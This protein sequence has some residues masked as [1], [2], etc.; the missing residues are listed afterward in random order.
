ME[1]IK[2]KHVFINPKKYYAIEEPDEGTLYFLTNGELYRGSILYGTQVAII[3]N[4][5]IPERGQVNRIYYNSDDQSLSVWKNKKWVHITPTISK[6][7]DL[8]DPNDKDVND[9]LVTVDNLKKYID[10]LIS[11]GK[12]LSASSG[13]VSNLPIGNIKVPKDI[14]VVNQE[15]GN[16]KSGD[17]VRAGTSIEKVLENLLTKVTP[18][19]YKKPKVTITPTNIIVE[20]GTERK[21]NFTIDYEPGDGGA[22]TSISLYKGN[23]NQYTEPI[24]YSRHLIKQYETETPDMIGEGHEIEYKVVVNYSDGKL[25]QDSSGELQELG[26]IKADSTESIFRCIGKRASWF[27]SIKED[28]DILI[29]S[30]IRELGES[31]L[32]IKKGDSFA[33]DINVGDKSVIIAIPKYL[34]EITSIISRTLNIDVTSNFK[35]STIMV[36]GANGYRSIDYYVYKY[37]PNIPFVSKDTFDIVV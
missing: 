9:N 15:I 11:T 4:S 2:L 37:T 24:F 13:A 23:D 14:P 30:D 20:V 7:I 29:S 25:V 21:F 36:E 32:D 27:K 33:L 1:N 28:K 6:T 34:G 3:D 19:E 17:I 12:V 16:Y 5:S 26:S 8:S 18:V 22:V 31:V 35:L 10:K